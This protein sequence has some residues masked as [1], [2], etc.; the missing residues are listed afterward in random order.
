MTLPTLARPEWL[1]LLVLALPILRLVRRRSADARAILV[2]HLPLL[3]SVLAAGD[4]PRRGP[5]LVPVALLAALA[6]TTLA[7][8]GPEGEGRGA[9][10]RETSPVRP[11]PGLVEGPSRA[12]AF[13][14]SGRALAASAEVRGDAVVAYAR[15]AAPPGPPG[16][17]GRTLVLGAPPLARTPIPETGGEV[18][19]EAV[20]PAIPGVARVPTALEGPDGARSPLA[21]A[22]VAV[23]GPRPAL[24]AAASG[25]VPRSLAAALAAL[26]D[27]VSSADLVAAG[28]LAAA[29]GPRS[30]T[31]FVLHGLG[32]S[33]APP[34]DVLCV[35]P[36]PGDP[37]LPVVAS[38]AD[39]SA[40]RFRGD[41]PV[42]R[43][44]PAAGL[45]FP[46]L[47]SLAEPGAAWRPLL[48]TDRGPA[49]LAG[50]PA[51][52]RRVVAI[53]GDPDASLAGTPVFPRLVRRSLAWLAAERAREGLAVVRA[54]EGSAPG[55]PGAAA[56]VAALGLPGFPAWRAG[57][58]GLRSLPA[59]AREVAPGLLLVVEPDPF[60][61]DGETPGP[62][63]PGSSPLPPSR[64]PAVPPPL[65]AA[66]ALAALASLACA[67]VP[68]RRFGPRVPPG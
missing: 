47:P 14:R 1:G 34:G 31:L 9:R 58:R 19:A 36:A 35:A 33:A 41:H 60:A 6:A 61:P 8:S 22:A 26:P 53:L 50:S 66:L 17:A 67:A 20:L 48:E 10:E 43:G 40:L 23:P 62:R 64:G 27:L 4:R 65:P 2:P 63:D 59:G 3:E 55:D 30:E 57:A 21:E 24:V 39:G 11:R 42:S 52:G 68:F 32:P 16:R 49:A 12:P 15:A 56:R 28:D 25:S 45:S 7:A 46:G 29:A 37:L 44:L 38:A 54:G 13:P 18:D 51:P 5:A